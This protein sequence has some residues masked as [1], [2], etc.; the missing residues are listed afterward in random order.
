MTLRFSLP[1]ATRAFLLGLG[2]LLLATG[3]GGGGGGAA[4]PPPP[5]DS[6]KPTVVLVEIVDN[7]PDEVLDTIEDVVEDTGA[8]YLGQVDGTTFH[9]FELPASL[10]PEAAS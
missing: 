7:D 1:T 8:T 3:C 9:R 10:S 6:P 4:S 2:L 5:P